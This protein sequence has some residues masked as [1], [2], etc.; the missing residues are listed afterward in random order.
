MRSFITD[1]FLLESPLAER[2]FQEYARAL[3]I[4]DYHNHLDPSWIARDHRFRSITELWLEGDHYK[5]RAQRT[6]GQ[7]ERLLTGDADD[8]EKFAAWAAAVP[9]TLGNPLY[10]WTHMELRF[11]LGLG[12]RL[13]EPACAR[14]VYEAVN[15][16]LADPGFSACGLLEQFRVE[17]VATTDDPV[18]SLEHHRAFKQ[19]RS[20]G[21]LDLRPTFRPDRALA[22]ED[23]AAFCAYVRA[24]E[25]SSG[26]A[27][28]RYEDLL[29]ALDRRHAFFHDVGCR[30]S[31][32]GITTLHAGDVGA[33]GVPETF[34]RVLAG[35]AAGPDESR[36]FRAELLHELLAMNHRRGWVQQ[37]HLGPLRNLNSRQLLALGPNTGFDAMGE[38]PIARPLATLLDRLDQKG[39]LAKTIVYG[40][41]PKDAELLMTILGCF[42]GD[43]PGKMQLGSAWWFLDQLDGMER[44]LRA[45]AHHGLLSQFVGMLTDSRSLLSMSRHEYFRRLVCNLLATDA[46]RGRLPGDIELLGRLVRRLSYENAKVY[47]S[48]AEV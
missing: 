4:I 3:P 40:I 21:A 1:S 9:E 5:W 7:S 2:L 34:L 38:D 8:W 31:D 36:A 22:I 45:V 28:Q 44:Q 33:S 46:L 29:E 23:T 27:I 20:A 35:G 15:V 39:Q 47:F 6:L 37:L 13:L 25:E 30:L 48:H 12:E 32:H 18:D 26:L 42:Q 41:H 14:E 11:P 10:H 17:L 24:L 16:R 19:K 43:V